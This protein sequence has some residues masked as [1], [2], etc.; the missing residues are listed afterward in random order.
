MADITNVASKMFDYVIVGGG[1]CTLFSLFSISLDVFY[2][3]QTTGLALASRLAEDPSVSV[4]VLEAGQS[5]L[6]DPKIVIPAQWKLTHTFG[7]P[8]VNPDFE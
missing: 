6:N 8:K 4:V 5:N 3:S 7:D 2:N 1:V